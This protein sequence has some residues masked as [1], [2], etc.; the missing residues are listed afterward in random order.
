MQGLGRADTTSL[1]SLA[2]SVFGRALVTIKFAG[3][4]SSGGFDYSWST[5]IKLK[6]I[7]RA[8]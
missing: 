4:T 8:R 2:K 7:K 3:H 6:L 5:I 1:T